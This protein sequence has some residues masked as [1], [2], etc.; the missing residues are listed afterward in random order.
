LYSYRRAAIAKAWGGEEWF[1]NIHNENGEWQL[2]KSRLAH[3]EVYNAIIEL[4]LS[5]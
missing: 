2:N 5:A 4:G 1:K 3:E